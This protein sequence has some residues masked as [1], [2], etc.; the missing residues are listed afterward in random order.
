MNLTTYNRMRYYIT[1]GSTLL[2]DNIQHRREIEIFISS[3]SRQVERYIDR[4]TKIQ[5]YTEYFDTRE[6]RVQ[7]FVRAIPVVTLTS[8]YEDSSGEYDGS[9]SEITD[10]IIGANNQSVVL[11]YPA[12][13][14]LK[15]VRIIYTGGMAYHAANSTFTVT[16]DAG[17]F[18]AGNY[19]I[20]QTSGARGLT[21]SQSGTA[22][23][24]ENLYGIF[25]ATEIIKEYDN[26]S[27]TG[28][29][30]GQATASAITQQSLAEAYPDVVRAAEM[31]IR[32]NWK[33]KNNFEN[34]STN[35]DSTTRKAPQ[36]SPVVEMQPE[37]LSLLNPY[38][39]IFI[40]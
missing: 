25:D 3:V 11:D 31:Q 28:T 16:V 27:G 6:D 17:S 4:E 10:S 15:G 14:S 33:H 8:V 20:G 39:R 24:I 1:Q 2:T 9:E 40:L 32:Y 7:Y 30:T 36:G 13:G 29:A 34:V 18:T 23:V 12:T 26:E 19:C 21:V 35:K 5:S 37:V 22:L 38:R